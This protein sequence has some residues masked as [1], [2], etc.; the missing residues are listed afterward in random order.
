MKIA[1]VKLRLSS[2]I[3]KIEEKSAVT[4]VIYVARE[5]GEE[6]RILK[7]DDNG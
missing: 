1:C 4:L 7:E 3:N 6:V 2:I 5:L